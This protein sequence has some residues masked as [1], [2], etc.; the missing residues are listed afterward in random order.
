[1]IGYPPP[2]S[3]VRNWFTNPEFT[4][5]QCDNRSSAFLTALFETTLD[6]IKEGI[7][8]AISTSPSLTK[9]EKLSA[10]GMFPSTLPEQFRQFMMVGQTFSTQG[11][12]RIQFYD[13]VLERADEVD[14]VQPNL[15]QR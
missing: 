2:D 14:L 12:L 10:L 1:L 8:N 3:K 5:T 7:L 13:R 9:A 11:S 6:V 15:A 4:P